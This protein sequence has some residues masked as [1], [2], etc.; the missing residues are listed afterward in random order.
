MKREEG[1]EN[2]GGQ[3][4]Y[5]IDMERT[6]INTGH[7]MVACGYIPEMGRRADH[8]AHDGAESIHVRITSEKGTMMSMQ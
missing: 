7:S 1:K 3:I 8:E 6:E 5:K 2:W 4:G